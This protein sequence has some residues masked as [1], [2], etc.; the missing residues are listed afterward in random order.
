MRKIICI[1]AGHRW[2]SGE[3]DHVT[4]KRRSGVTTAAA[5]AR[6]CVRC[7]CRQYRQIDGFGTMAR[8]WIDPDRMTWRLNSDDII[9]IVM[10][11]CMVVGLAIFI[12]R[13]PV[14]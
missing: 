11:I 4:I 9:G 7:S 12:S 6:R 13:S 8:E 3:N 10:F 14:A 2:T 5:F 1:I